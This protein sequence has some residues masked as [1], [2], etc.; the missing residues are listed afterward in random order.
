MTTMTAPLT[1][2]M[3]PDLS[4]ALEAR[5]DRR[6]RAAGIA[7]LAAAA[8]GSVLGASP[9]VSDAPSTDNHCRMEVV[10]SHWSTSGCADETPATSAR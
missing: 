2:P 10:R 3:T 8:L 7:V 4:T 6:L 1:T 5:T 9:A